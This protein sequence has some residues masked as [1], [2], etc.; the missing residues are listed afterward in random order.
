MPY[1][2]Q[3]EPKPVGI[4][5][6][7]HSIIA[8]PSESSAQPRGLMG[9]PTELRQVIF[10]YVIAI[11][12]ADDDINETV[13]LYQDETVTNLQSTVAINRKIRQ[14]MLHVI[15][16]RLEAVNSWLE[17]FAIAD[18][19]STIDSIQTSM[20]QARYNVDREGQMLDKLKK[21]LSPE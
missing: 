4:A 14:E 3:S 7:Q 11:P 20:R 5:T 16:Q 19:S 17:S 21:N 15:K 10:A 12:L 6:P 13:T 18:D 2:F 9:L 1:S 8:E